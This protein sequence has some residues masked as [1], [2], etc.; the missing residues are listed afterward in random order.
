[1]NKLRILV[2]S[3]LLAFTFLL[4]AS[5]AHGQITPS[6]DAYT[7][8]ASPNTNY[9]TAVTLNVESASQTAYIQFD[10]SAI[11]T[12]YT[13]ANIAKA[14]LKL[15]VNA[16]STAGSFNIDY[17]DGAWT[18]STINANLLPAM[19][20]TI[21]SS[22]PLVKSNAHDY[23]IIDVTSAVDAWLNGTQ[24]ND[25]I[26][27]VANSP[28]SCSFTS[29]ESTTYSHPPE[30]D[31]V[32]LG[33]GAQG[34][35]GPQGPE[36][37]QGP[38]GV[39]GPS[40]PVGP[41][42]PVGP[43]GI[44]NRGTWVATTAYQIN[45]SV[46][47]AGASWI[48]LVVNTDSA[49]GPINTN[50]Q[51]MAAKGMNNQ[52]S[53]VSSVNYQVDDAVTDGGQFWIAVAV[54]TQS[55]PSILNPNWQLVAAS[56]ATGPTGA[57]GPQGPAGQTGSTGPAGQTGPQGSQG[58]AGPQGPIGLTGATGAQGPQ[59]PTGST[60]LSGPQGPIGLTGA[61]G[62]QGATGATGLMGLTGAQ[63]PQGP[64]GPAG[65]NG[66][67]FNFR[68]TF[69]TSATYAVNDVATYNGST[70]VAIA[71][72][73]PSSQ[74]PDQNPSAWSVMAQ[75]GATGQTGAPGA[76]GATGPQGPI[77]LTGTTGAQGAT[78]SQGATGA[79]GPQGPIGATGAQGPQG[80]AGPAA[81]TP[82]AMNAALLRWY[83]QTFPVGTSPEGVVFDGTNIWVANY[84][85]SPGAGSV[86]ELLA[87]SGAV[88]GTFPIAG[89]PYGLAFDGT[90][91]WVANN[92]S[93][94]TVIKLLA[95]T[96]AVVG[97]YSVGSFPVEVAFDGT[98]I[99]VTNNSGSSVT[100]LL[101][102]TGAVVGT[103]SVGSFPV[104]V[105]FDGTN[106]W[107]ASTSGQSVTKLLASTGAVVGT[108]PIPPCQA[109]GVVFDGINIW[110]ACGGDGITKLLATTGANEAVYGYGID[111]ALAF[112]GNNMWAANSASGS[113]TV[114]RFVASTGTLVGQYT[115][116]TNP[117]ALAFDGANMWVTN[118]GSNTVTK[119]PVN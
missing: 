26:A 45:D 88:V 50:W 40:G 116:G 68:N 81:P 101:A 1:M 99:W 72:N 94:G 60:G 73:G 2:S 112:D 104:G 54:N 76:P 78:G 53:W 64:Q 117:V 4:G 48:A 49:P 23:I 28:L 46:A 19:G 107:V 47:Y 63:G 92:V 119:I 85:G 97:T 38:Q 74:T 83:S 75:Q 56:G 106:I 32:F 91:I 113:T 8:A 102:S 82:A 66:T 95:S 90:N 42:G 62:P 105:A 93:S 34:P 69:A 108:Y 14:S 10:L 86:T 36:G 65:T 87:S 57:A 15:Y 12:G 44:N 39:S 31:I 110:V 77:G 58:A 52:G 79:T 84:G 37:P 96:G 24:A 118:N 9:G 103:Y 18:E 25:G 22:V 98:N 13:G 29:K 70:Y 17:V 3:A 33:N 51:L 43:A 20:T 11:P 111:V 71:A 89:N 27:L 55:E 67:G 7:N 5:G 41:Q 80:P 16:V 35:A 109:T 6:A 114:V 61:T 21:A 30:L 100:K 59:G 115:P